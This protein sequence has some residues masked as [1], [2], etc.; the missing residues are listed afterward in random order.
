MEH[1]PPIIADNLGLVLFGLLILYLQIKQNRKSRIVEAPAEQPE[2]AAPAT[3]SKLRKFLKLWPEV[4]ILP[5]LFAVAAGLNLVVMV[6]FPDS[7]FLVPEQIQTVLYK[8]LGAFVAYFLFF[9]RDRLDFPE[10]SKWY[11]NGI[12]ND[13]NGMSPWQKSL[14][15][16]WRLSVFVLVFALF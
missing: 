5:L 11:E 15:Y 1:L 10:W 8:S 6:V 12:D 16:T 2:P 14:L 4:W 9:V 13:F 7:I 3:P